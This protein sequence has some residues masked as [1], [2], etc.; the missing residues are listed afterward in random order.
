MSSVGYSFGIQPRL[1]ASVHVDGSRRGVWDC[2]AAR[3]ET[4]TFLSSL[5]ASRFFN[6]FYLYGLET[7]SRY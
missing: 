5:A 2:A 3:L 1:L 4:L 6:M 7:V